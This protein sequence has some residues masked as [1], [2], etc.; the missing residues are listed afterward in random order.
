MKEGGGLKE[1][2]KLAQA[3][4]TGHGPTR[5]WDSEK[6]WP[7][8]AARLPRRGTAGFGRLRLLSRWNGNESVAEG[9]GPR[10]EEAG[11]KE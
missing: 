1:P 8:P 10:E 6:E 9:A 5:Q 2:G 4:G 3:G 11:L 7:L